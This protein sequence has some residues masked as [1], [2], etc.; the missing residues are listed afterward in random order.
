MAEIKSVY[1]GQ[2]KLVQKFRRQVG[3][4]LQATKLREEQLYEEQR[5]HHHF[6]S[7]LHTIIASK[8][9]VIAELQHEL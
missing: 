5:T 7:K 3:R 1:S 4:M 2:D 9:D 8:D 6:T